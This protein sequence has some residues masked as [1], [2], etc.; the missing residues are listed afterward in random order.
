MPWNYRTNT[1]LSTDEAANGQ[2]V[3]TPAPP[4]T[5]SNSSSTPASSSGK[6]K[7]RRSTDEPSTAEL[8]QMLQ[9][10]GKEEDES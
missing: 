7:K 10:T 5:A 1:N 9:S 8:V 4:E 2:D 3:S 6:S